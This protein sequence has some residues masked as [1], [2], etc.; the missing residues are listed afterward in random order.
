MQVKA[1]QSACRQ[2][3][4]FDTPESP[5]CCVYIMAFYAVQHLFF[6]SQFFGNMRA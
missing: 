5:D 6:L 3:G 2:P 4:L 1:Y